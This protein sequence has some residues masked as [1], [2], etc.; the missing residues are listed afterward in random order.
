MQ[1]DEQP[2]RGD[3]EL[4]G[5]GPKFRDALRGMLDE[6]QMFRDFEGGEIECLADFVTAY[7]AKK[8]TQVFHEGARDPFMALVAEGRLEVLKDT[9]EK[10]RRQI[11]VVRPGK[12]VG[13][14]SLIDELPHSATV[15]A[16][17]PTTLLLLTKEGYRRLGQAHPRLALKV[18]WQIA[19]LM[20]HRLR[21]TSGILVDY[22]EEGQTSND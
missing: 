11:A 12:T 14:M 6:I 2:K 21:Q 22:L 13:E 17:E 5:Y 9:Y 7:K 20:S 4:L 10:G 1:E 15:V 18:T 19:R 8:G 3:L 16:M